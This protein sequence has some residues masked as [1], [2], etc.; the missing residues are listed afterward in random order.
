MSGYN[1]GTNMN[2]KHFR[3]IS[4]LVFLL[5]ITYATPTQAQNCGE[6]YNQG[7]CGCSGWITINFPGASQGWCVNSDMSGCAQYACSAVG[8]GGGVG[9]MDD[10]CGSNQWSAW[11]GFKCSEFACIE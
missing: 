9:Y 4:A 7:G 10:F 11:Y 1:G 5:A 6:I 2:L 8:C 3:N